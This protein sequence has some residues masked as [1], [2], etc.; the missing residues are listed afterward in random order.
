MQ[1]VEARPAR[2]ATAP[3]GGELAG[4]LRDCA[5]WVPGSLER[6][7]ATTPRGCVSG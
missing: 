7:R 5:E 1:T 6:L 4:I 3:S 2:P